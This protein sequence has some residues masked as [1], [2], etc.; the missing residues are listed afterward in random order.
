[1]IRQFA[2]VALLGM[3][4]TTLV[5]AQ[6]PRR[7]MGPPG[8]GP[9]HQSL[10]DELKLTDTQQAQLEKIRLDLMKKQT[11]LRSKVQTLRLEIQ[12]QFL[13]DKI[14][15]AAIEKNLKA[16]TDLQQQMKLNMLDHWFQV[17]A[18]LTPEQQ[19]IW[20][21][22]PMRWG[23]H[24]RDGMRMGMRGMMRFRGGWDWDDADSD[25]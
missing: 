10:I 18:I 8:K 22:A 20:K 19:K 24:M 14:D 2:A 9:H 16:I 17:N 12:E 23:Q 7:P 15:R 21:S 3:L 25:D 4:A 11:P 13:A 1:M 5:L 6:P